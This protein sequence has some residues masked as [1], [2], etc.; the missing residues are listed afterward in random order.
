MST[1][2]AFFVAATALAAGFSAQEADALTPLSVDAS[3]TSDAPAVREHATLAPQ[4]FERAPDAAYEPTARVA[5]AR[6]NLQC[7][8]FARQE[9]GL[10]IY[11]DANT[12][13]AQAKDKFHRQT[14]PVEAGVLVLRGYGGAQRGHVA[15]IRE[16]VSE[17]M[18]IVDHANWLNHGEVTRNVPVRDVSDRGD[19]SAVQVWNVQTAQWGAREYQVQGV[20]V[21][22]QALA[23]SREE[24]PAA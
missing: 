4:A 9:A 22:D 10:E 20:I 14:E 1:T 23:K 17:R 15:V 24:A 19:W 6:A 5:N 8:P 12:W 11:G 13:W 16:V 18:V 21:P 3:I 2:R 7:V